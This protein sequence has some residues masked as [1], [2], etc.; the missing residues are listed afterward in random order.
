MQLNQAKNQFNTV[1]G[2]SC[3]FQNTVFF[4]E[5]VKQKRKQNKNNNKKS[6]LN[7]KKCNVPGRH[8]QVVDKSLI[9][10]HLLMNCLDITYN[11]NI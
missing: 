6:Q 11:S 5:I 3:C 1:Q 8:E 7:Q 10:S 2:T 9:S 4:P